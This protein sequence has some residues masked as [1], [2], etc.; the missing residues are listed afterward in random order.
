MSEERERARQK[1]EE[2][3]RFP[4]LEPADDYVGMT[5]DH[6]FGQVWTRPGLSRKERRWISLTAIAC[7]G[8]QGALD[9]H[10]RSA[11]QSGDITRD[12]MLEFSIH[13]AHYAGWPLSSQ[14]YATATR[15]ADE[16]ES[17]G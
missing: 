15:I 1:W 5:L 7:A 8:V 17:E 3:N 4:A 14:L 9:V 13:F 11:L 10:V 2:V 12:E 16:L 6:V